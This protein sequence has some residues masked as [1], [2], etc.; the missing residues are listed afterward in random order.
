MVLQGFIIL[1][2]FI[3]SS[4]GHIEFI[5]TA[6]DEVKLFCDTNK[7]QIST[8]SNNS[9]DVNCTVECVHGEA[10]KL[11]NIQNSC[12][13]KDSVKVGEKCS[14]IASS[15]FYR[16]VTALDSGFLFPFKPSPNTV[17][18]YIVA[19]AN[20]EMTTKSEERSSV[21]L[22]EGE[23]VLLNCSVIFTK[24][25]YHKEFVV[26]WIK[27]IGKNSTCVYSYD[28]D[29]Y[30]GI[31]YNPH[32]NVQEELLYRLSDQTE[33]KNSHNIRISNVTDS[34]G[35]QYLCAL[36]VHTHDKTKG[37][38]KIINNI[39]VSV[40]KDK[41]PEIAG[42]SADLNPKDPIPKD[43]AS[44]STGNNTESLIRLCV[45][46]PVILGIPAALMVVYLWKKMKISPRSQAMELQTIQH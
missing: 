35:G 38:W 33:G 34:D 7:W 9:I 22:T 37:K 15:G 36:Q 3:S 27:T 8:E 17:T 30:N 1:L 24:E 19:T 40:Q 10:L 44:E 42:N 31:T 2:F 46:L 45:T 13:N 4:H 20:E 26:Y 41:G 43:K 5:Y 28:F 29:L 14:L 39:T 18:S 21:K 6:K 25:N 11:N 12:K 32:C 16:C 23:D